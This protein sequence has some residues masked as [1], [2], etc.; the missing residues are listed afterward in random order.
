[1]ASIS[2][3]LDRIKSDLRRFLPDATIESAARDAGHRWRRRNLGPVQTV[4]LF[5]LQVLDA[6]NGTRPNM[7]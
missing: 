7:K 5:I 4:H 2:G 3:A 1:M 6:N